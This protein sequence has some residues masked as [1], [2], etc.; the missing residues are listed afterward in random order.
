MSKWRLA[1]QQILGPSRGFSE[2]SESET[3][4]NLHPETRMDSGDAK[5][6]GGCSGLS[7]L[8]GYDPS[9]KK[10]ISDKL[11]L[12]VEKYG[13]TYNRRYVDE[14]SYIQTP[15]QKP[16]KPEQPQ[17]LV[18]SVNSVC[19]VRPDQ[20]IVKAVMTGDPKRIAAV[21][22]ANSDMQERAAIR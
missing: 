19:A 6:Q 15:Q 11:L 17:K 9:P 12:K 8:F 22:A 2:V 14:H 1:V 13:D 5:S 20:A 18:Y 10:T 21:V 3:S 16:N 7:G 4:R